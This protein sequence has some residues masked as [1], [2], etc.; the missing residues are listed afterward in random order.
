[1]PAV[2]RKGVKNGAG[3][4]NKLP[5]SKRCRDRSIALRWTREQIGLARDGP[6]LVLF[7]RGDD[8]RKETAVMHGGPEPV[9]RLQMVRHAVA[10][11]LF[12][13]IARAILGERAHQ[14]VSRD[15]GDD[16]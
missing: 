10:L 14:P 12:E 3:A 8:G 6:G 16:G 11:V 4:A 2:D 7:A 13:A 1:M 15:F 5:F 9:Q